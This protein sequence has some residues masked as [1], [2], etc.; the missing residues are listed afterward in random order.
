VNGEYGQWGETN[1]F[2]YCTSEHLDK[3]HDTG[4]TASLLP[5]PTLLA[6]ATITYRLVTPLL[7][8]AFR[9]SVTLQILT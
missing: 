5:Q 7:N 1:V 4:I 8:A 2:Q 3:V 6:A 9:Q